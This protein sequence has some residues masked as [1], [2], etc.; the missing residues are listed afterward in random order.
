[1]LL[2]PL[3]DGDVLTYE[4]LYEPGQV[5][6]HPALDRLVFLCEPAGVRLHW[7]TGG[8]EDLFGLAGRQRR[9]RARESSRAQGAAA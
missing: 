5:M 4:F 1:M 9:R 6:V 8:P 7:M 3:Q 2:P